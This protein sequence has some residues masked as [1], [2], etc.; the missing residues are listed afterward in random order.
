MPGGTLMLLA[1]SLLFVYFILCAP[2]GC[3]CPYATTLKT[4]LSPSAGTY[5]CPF[6]VT[7]TKAPNVNPVS[8]SY[9]TSGSD[10]GPSG[11]TKADPY[12]SDDLQL[13]VDHS[14]K[15][16]AYSHMLGYW[17]DWRK[18]ADEPV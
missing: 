4:S 1:R 8:F 7:L 16:V 14:V 17:W 18:K 3:T 15:L 11:G 2:D 6:T 5:A 13:T 9:S 10:P 12:P